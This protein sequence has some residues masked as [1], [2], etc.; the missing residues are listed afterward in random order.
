MAL[1]DPIKNFAFGVIQTPPSPALSGT[2]LVLT[3]GQGVNFPSPSP[4]PFNALVWAGPTVLPTAANAEIVRVT[5]ISTDTFT[6]TRTQE[7]SIAR[8]IVQGDYVMLVATAKTM[9]D[10]Q[11]LFPL[12]LANGGTGGTSASTARTA[13]GLVIG[14]NVEAWAAN[15]DTWATV[16]P[17]VGAPVG[18][19]DT[20]TLT[21]KTLQDSDNWFST[22]DTWVYVS[23][24]SFKIT[25]VDRTA[26]FTKGTRVKCTNNAITFYGTVASS[27]FGTD[28]TV[29]LFANNDFSLANSAIT[30]PFYS[31]AQN[32][33]GYPGR[34]SYTPTYSAS[35]GTYSATDTAYFSVN[36]RTC[37]V[38]IYSNGS[39][40][41]T[42]VEMTAT[43]PVNAVGNQGFG[44][45]VNDGSGVIAGTAYVGDTL[46][47][48][49]VTNY[50]NVAFITGASHTIRGNISY[51]Y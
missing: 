44:L 14:T 23:A 39:L 26:R 47:V 4:T 6:I 20:Q 29:T 41:G 40:S 22:A 10:I 45:Q 17:P 2:S 18:T 19:T 37:T 51:F 15:L 34:F 31:Y 16:V 42:P 1:F 21:N 24:S 3:A 43:L 5:A 38:N 50:S 35:A 48:L 33:Q 25:G 36:G 11:N 27:V 46:N 32:P 7:G 9:T 49:H 13:L 8:Q 28:T 30:S 12:S